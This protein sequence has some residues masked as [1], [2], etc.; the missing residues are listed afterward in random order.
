M[1]DY[2]LYSRVRRWPRRILYTMLVL[3]VLVAG[4]VIVV[5]RV[6]DAN[7]KPVSSSTEQI[8]FVVPSGASVHEI[9]T[10][11]HKAGLIRQVWAFERYVRNAN[12]GSK[13]QAGTYKF[14]QSQDV[15][16]ISAMM[17]QGKVAVDLITLLPGQRIDQ[18]REAFIRA[19]FDPA[20]VDE[21][22]DPAQYADSPALADKPTGTSLEG[23]L[24]PDSY[25]KDANTDPKVIVEAALKEMEEHLTTE[26]RTAFAAHGL[27]V[28]QAVTMASIIEREVSNA[29]DRAQVAQVFYK[30]MA[31]GMHLESDVTA[32]YGAIK[33]GKKPAISYDSPY[34]TYKVLG[35]PVGPIS[36]VSD[37]SLDAVAHPADSDW[38]YFVAGDDGKTYFSKTLE[39]HEAL[40]AEHCH[41]LCSQ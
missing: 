31:T 24:Y 2:S 23:F 7:L 39:D 19:K 41:K 37:S 12:L 38:L 22:F 40:T 20:A 35:L 36:N 15:Q 34:N 26:R 8:A 30:R 10:D 9:G 25:Q 16:T 29:G 6:Y 32:F 14:S 18:L 33:D 13:L 3:L 5:R 1:A 28:Y 11:L 27:T 17:A 21:A 4:S